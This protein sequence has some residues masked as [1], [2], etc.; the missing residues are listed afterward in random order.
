MLLLVFFSLKYYHKYDVLKNKKKNG[1]KP[2]K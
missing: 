2:S 1:A